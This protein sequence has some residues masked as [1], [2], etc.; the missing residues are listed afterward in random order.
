[1]LQIL[2]VHLL[3]EALS[4]TWHWLTGSK[5]GVPLVTVPLSD[6]VITSAH[7]IIFQDSILTLHQT[8]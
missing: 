1:M 7:L 6:P 8:G 2:A 3:S 4:A 5:S